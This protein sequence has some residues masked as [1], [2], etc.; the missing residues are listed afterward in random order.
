MIEDL[1]TAPTVKIEID[2]LS[3]LELPFM[4]SQNFTFIVANN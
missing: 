3:K 4:V 2:L 1:T